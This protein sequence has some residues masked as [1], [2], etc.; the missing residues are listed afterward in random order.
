MPYGWTLE[1]PPP[2]RV[3]T[4]EDERKLKEKLAK[5]DLIAVDTETTGLDIARDIVVYWSL[6][7][8]DDRYFLERDRL[9]NFRPVFEDKTKSWVGSQI[10]YDLNILA[11]CGITVA[12]DAM[13]T[14]TMDRLVDP[15]RPHGLKD[16]YQREFNERMMSFAETFY[17]RDT[18]G[19]P[20]RPPKKEMHEILTEAFEKDPDRVVDYASLDAWSVIRLFHRLKKHLKAIETWY[21]YTFWDVFLR[22][23]VPMTRVLF[24]ME[25]NGVLLDIEYLQQIRPQVVE[26]IDST[27]ARLNQIAGW[28]V[29]PNSGPQLAKLLFE[30]L[31]CEPIEYTG[32]GKTGVKKPSTKKTVL[33]QLAAEGVE[34]ADLILEHRG[35]SKLIGTY[36]DGLIG[37][38]DDA[39]RVHT[40]FNQHVADTGRLSSSDP[41]LQNQTRSGSALFDIRKAFIP[42]PGYDMIV[43]DYDQLE[44]YI[45]G[46]YSGDQ[47]LISAARSGRDIHTANVELVYG[48]PYEEVLEAKK[49]P[50]DQR[51]ARQWE[52]KKLRDGTKNIGFGLA[53]GKAARALGIDLGYPNEVRE[54]YP[55]WSDAAVMRES[56]KMAQEKIDEFFEQIPGAYDFIQGTLRR[57]SDDKYTEGFLGRR[58]WFFD[59]ME[60]HDQELHREAARAKRRK[61]CWCQ[62]C[63]LSR[64]GDRA[65]INHIIQG[66]AADIVML[67]MIRCHQD[68]LLRKLGVKMLLQVHD[69][70]VFEVPKESTQEA[71]PII[72]HLMENPGLS[73]EVP[74]RAAP[75]VGQNWDEAK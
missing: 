40:T 17:P 13:C 33:K 58:R 50:G 44:M 29:N 2:I 3:K 22:F 69:E 55:E 61:L 34:A 31:E 15:G 6:S 62:V 8:G 65:A 63:K 57:V 25:R 1:R 10:K 64:D 14:L 72:Q 56:T 28:A 71:L 75:G 4:D 67:A 43:A 70:L 73:L 26:K 18:K 45:L 35:L 52:L 38:A 59:I 24:E 66:T 53:Y 49:T 68:P 51:T 23:E 60:W 9:W 37:R 11:N 20:R 47:G 48:E 16:A 41:N 46:H 21:G 74:L 39:G 30:D 12:G 42:S 32:G 36:I 5:F 7:T 27:G 19:K 54:S